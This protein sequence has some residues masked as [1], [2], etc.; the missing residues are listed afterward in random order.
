MPIHSSSYCKTTNTG[1][2]TSQSAVSS[3]TVLQRTRS[4]GTTHELIWSQSS[5][6]IIHERDWPSP[7]GRSTQDKASGASVAIPSPETTLQGLETRSPLY[8]DGCPSP[9]I[10]SFDVDSVACRRLQANMLNE[11]LWNIYF[12]I[13]EIRYATWLGNSCRPYLEAT[14]V[15]RDKEIV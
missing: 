11:I 10:S 9:S 8:S 2:Q 12:T 5:D 14:P 6:T 1:H 13:F 3:S 4:D 7:S 15:S